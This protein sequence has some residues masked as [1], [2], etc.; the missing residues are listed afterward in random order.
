VS[1][2][3]LLGWIG[4]KPVESPFIEIGMGATFF[5]FVFFLFLLPIIGLVENSLISSEEYS[6]L[7]KEEEEEEEKELYGY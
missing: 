1:D 6:K 4:Q 3:L 7:D 2:F 5:Y